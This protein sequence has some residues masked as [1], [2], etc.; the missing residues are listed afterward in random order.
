MASGPSAAVA[1]QLR[2]LFRGGTV[3]GLTDGQ[4]LDR[5]VQRRDESAFAA[6]VERH[7]PMVLRVCRSRLGD[8][9]DAED[10]FQATFL[11]LARK[12]PSIRRSEAVAGWL[13]GVAG[14]V[15]AKVRAADRRRMRAEQKVGMSPDLGRRG[16]AARAVDRALPGARS[17]AGEVPAAADPLLPGRADLRAGRRAPGVPGPDD[18]EPVGAGRNGCGAGWSAADWHRRPR[19]WDRPSRSIEA[20]DRPGFVE[21][22]DGRGRAAVLERRRDGRRGGPGRG[23]R[24]GGLA[25]HVLRSDECRRDARRC[26]W[27]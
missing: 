12:A 11:V 15:S 21:A 9:H 5:F 16:R 6:L 7:G 3:G 20:G 17:A 19:S 22:S 24:R 27:D 1:K 4:L 18:P 10:A 14:R 8:A 25:R 26:C 2:A 13:F 23:P